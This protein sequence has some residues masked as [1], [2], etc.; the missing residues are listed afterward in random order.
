[1]TKNSSGAIQLAFH[2]DQTQLGF[3]SI[4]N[5]IIKMQNSV[6]ILPSGKI[7]Y[8]NRNFVFECVPFFFPACMASSIFSDSIGIVFHYFIS[9]FSW[10]TPDTTV[11]KGS[12]SLLK[13]YFDGVTSK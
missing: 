12:F 9:Q 7:A 10:F 8:I 11:A 13:R 6:C 2:L 3:I 1:L 4:I 5:V